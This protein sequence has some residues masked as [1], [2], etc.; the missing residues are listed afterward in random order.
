MTSTFW[1]L[2]DKGE[3]YA[4][5]SLCVMYRRLEFYVDY[6]AAPTELAGVLQ[7]QG[8]RCRAEIEDFPSCRTTRLR[9]I[10]EEDD[11]AES[12]VVDPDDVVIE[13]GSPPSVLTPNDSP[14]TVPYGTTAPDTMP[15]TLEG[16]R[17][18]ILSRDA[19]DDGRYLVLE[20][21]DL[22]D[23]RVVPSQTYTVDV[24]EDRLVEAWDRDAGEPHVPCLLAVELRTGCLIFQHSA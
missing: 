17:M 14:R 8:G 24:I 6:N 19:A 3:V 18:L 20:E 16:A 12:G 21:R 9:I 13:A 2:R 4:L 15:V 23:L 10:Q 7:E 5:C 1:L 22:D 11:P